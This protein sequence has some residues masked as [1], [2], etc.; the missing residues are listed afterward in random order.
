M[1]KFVIISLASLL[2]MS[3]KKNSTASVQ[4]SFPGYYKVKKIT[5]TVA[6]DM[7]NDGLKSSNLYYEISGLVTGPSGQRMSFYDFESFRNYLEVRPLDYQ[8]SNAKLIVWY[9]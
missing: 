1:Y 4:D 5:S 9:E 2:F 7:N 6:V 8:T 3:C